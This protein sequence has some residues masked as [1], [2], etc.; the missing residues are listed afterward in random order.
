MRT[1]DIKDF[2]NYNYPTGLVTAPDGKHGAFAVVNI[3]ESGNSYDSCLW[4]MDM[5][6]GDYRKLTSGGKERKFIWLDNETLLFVSNREKSYQEK[7]KNG[8]IWTCFYK[9][10]I[11]GGEAEFAFAVPHMVT[12][13]KLA[14]EK[15]FPEAVCAV[16]EELNIPAE[17][18]TYVCEIMPKNGGH[19]YQFSYRVVGR[20]LSGESIESTAAD[21]GEVRCCHE[22]YPYGAPGFPTPHFD[23]EFWIPL[24]WVLDERE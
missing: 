14:G 6:S 16:L 22:P 20:I 13:M 11:Y 5:E 23:L 2:M 24:P 1:I 15:R 21:W 17:K 12:N 8:E 10:S 19:L 9:I 18:A 4:I 7:M 3:N